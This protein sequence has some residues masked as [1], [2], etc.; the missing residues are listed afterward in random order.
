MG[1]FIME[2]DYIKN[3]NKVNNYNLDKSLEKEVAKESDLKNIITDDGR[4]Q[5][6]MGYFW[7]D[8][9]DII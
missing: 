9:E 5:D 8:L 3:K 4:I 6:F 1:D 7:D 2:E